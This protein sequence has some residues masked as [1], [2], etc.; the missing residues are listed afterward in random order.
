M[1]IKNL[2][3]TIENLLGLVKE[4]VTDDSHNLRRDTATAL[5]NAHSDVSAE[6]AAVNAAIDA[7]AV[8][9]ALG[10]PALVAEYAAQA[11]A[12]EQAPAAEPVA[13]HVVQAPAVEQAPAAEPVA[14]HAVQAPAVEQAPTAEPM[15]EHAIEA[16]SAEQTP[17]AP[18]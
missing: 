13:E 9:P 8:V 18:L 3:L 7:G 12:V 15:A 5:T 10:G 2:L 17:A 6:L 4:T 11:P 16:P 14:E 1:D